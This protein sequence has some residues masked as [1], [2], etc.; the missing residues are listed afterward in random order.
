LGKEIKCSTIKPHW[1]DPFVD[2]LSTP[3]AVKVAE[4]VPG[5]SHSR[6]KPASLEWVSIPDLVSPYKITFKIPA[7]F[8]NRILLPRRQQ[9]TMDNA[10]SA[11]L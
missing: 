5:T 4:I 3:T 2:V 6:V 11:L 9:E 10:T 7:P 8:P 1:K